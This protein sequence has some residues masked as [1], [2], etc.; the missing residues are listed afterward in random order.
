[1]GFMLIIAS[2]LYAATRGMNI[3][4]TTAD[5]TKISLYRD[6][7]ALIV[8]NSNYIN[9]WDPI[10]G[11]IQDVKEVAAVLEKQ[12]FKV[13][14]KTDLTK[15]EFN[16]A[17][18]EFALK[19]GKSRDNRLLFYYAGHGYTQKMAT[20]EELG[21]LVMT[22]APV[23]EKDPIGFSLS[24]V[25]MQSIVT[26]AKII[27][28]RHVLFMFDSC[29]SGSII[30][31]RE[32][33][34]PKS[35][36]DNAKYPVRQF[37]TAGRSNEPVPDRSVF[38]QAFLDLLEGRDEEP[39]P[40]NYITGEELGLYLKTKVPEYNP[41]QHP[42]YGKIR[43]PRLDKGDFVFIL[44]IKSDKAIEKP[45]EQPAGG[46]ISVES[47][48]RD[49]EI[50]VNG[51]HLGTT[52]L[53]N[54]AISP[55]PHKITVKKRGYTA[56]EK[57]ID[58]E[59]GRSVSMYV[60]LNPEAAP[61]TRAA[62]P[63]RLFVE[64]T[65]ED[66]TVKILN[67][68]P[69]FYQ[70]IPLEAGSY[71]VQVT[72]PEH[73]PKAMWISVDAGE[74][75]NMSIQLEDIVVAKKV[76]VDKKINVQKETGQILKWSEPATGMK[77]TWIHGGCFQMGSPESEPGRD[78]DEGPLH[79]VC[80]SGY[81][82][83]LY[84][85]S[86]AQF[87]KFRAS[88]NSKFYKRHLLNLN[89]DDQPAVRVSWKDAK[90]FAAWLTAQ[91]NNKYSFRLPTEAEWEYAC[92]AGALTARF[93]GNNPDD[94]CL[95]ANVADQTAKSSWPRAKIHTCNDGY[96][97]SA[98]VDHFKPNAFGLY[99]ILGNVWEWCEDNYDKNAYGQH[100]RE[101]PIHQ[102]A[103]AVRV[104]R[105]GSWDNSPKQIRCADRNA[106]YPNDRYIGIGFRLVR[107]P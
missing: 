44:P 62:Q 72:A 17:L 100:Q 82:M 90:A 43:D 81:W 89:A 84:E 5:G 1:M 66:A 8:G 56:Y 48:V 50:Y 32:R 70:G 45:S 96:T 51:H 92:R 98:P 55:G 33:I 65:P 103:S 85:V 7:Y 36:S 46:T 80:V 25:D 83:G 77:F 49:S 105:G 86:N 4:L 14:L 60:D 76:E 107:Q 35:I 19:Y 67:I 37:I 23:P 40:D 54:A 99:N 13:T 26:Q 71:H 21:Y 53:N 34:I 68:K 61:A 15:D 69:K 38:K 79:E 52:P 12:D 101:N 57:Q 95:Y 59:S 58:V 104:F 63:A 41:A 87:R 16:R 97:V 28:A 88:H 29:F 102:A 74:D 94:A 18:G 22:N 78:K 27:R 106:N 39:I 75:K 3:S 2:S 31:M 30:N 42:Q 9:G 73:R 20:G 64:T 24:S 93:W 91:N 11:A 47:S 10:P 6:S